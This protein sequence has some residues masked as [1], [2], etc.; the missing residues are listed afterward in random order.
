M[1]QKTTIS[2]DIK[3]IGQSS[4]HLLRC[5]TVCKIAQLGLA[6]T[7]LPQAICPTDYFVIFGKF[8]DV[9]NQSAVVKW[10]KVILSFLK[11]NSP[12]YKDIEIDVSIL[13]TSC[14]ETLASAT[15]EVICLKG[16]IGD[17]GLGSDD[18][19]TIFKLAK[20]SKFFA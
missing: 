17:I 16:L 9:A 19:V 4:T 1:C 10:L 5:H 20:C 12:A 2:A 11:S 18:P 15:S 6:A 14:P 13:T 8:A 3:V 7:L